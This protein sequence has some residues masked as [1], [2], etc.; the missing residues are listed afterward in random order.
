MLITL[1]DGARAGVMAFFL[2]VL[3]YSMVKNE[4]LIA[5]N[6][7]ITT[8]AGIIAYAVY[9]RVIRK[10]MRYKSAKFSILSMLLVTLTL[11][12]KLNPVTII[13]YGFINA[14]MMP[15]Y[16]T[17]LA[18]SYWT[19]LEKL[20]E[21][22]KCRPETHAARENYFAL[23]RVIG[24][25]FAVALPATAIGSVIVVFCLIAV[26]YIGLLLARRIMNDLDN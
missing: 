20:P 7:F 24:I 9:A 23:G 4:S 18:N 11:L 8:L 21:L 12:I 26:Q 10:N 14:F 25:A 17:P 1:L 3:L 15:F 16:I 19:V 6:T 22:D 2:N 13:V 5:A